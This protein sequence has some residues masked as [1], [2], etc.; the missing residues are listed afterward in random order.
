MHYSMWSYYRNYS[1]CSTVCKIDILSATPEHHYVTP[2]LGSPGLVDCAT[3][4]ICNGCGFKSL[5]KEFL[6]DKGSIR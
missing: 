3:E 1:I 4:F 6:K 2:S 5:L